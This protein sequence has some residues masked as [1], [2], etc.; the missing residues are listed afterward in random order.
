VR[1]RDDDLSGR[2]RASTAL[3]S[4]LVEQEK[5]GTFEAIKDMRREVIG[6]I[7][8]EYHGRIVKLMGDGAIAEFG[9]VIDAVACAD[10][11]S[12]TQGR[13]ESLPR[14]QSPPDNLPPVLAT[15]LI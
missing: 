1:A 7:V 3:Y 4:R 5:A 11:A 10:R 14:R 12:R 2:C 13:S 9:S 15:H 6:P 8:A